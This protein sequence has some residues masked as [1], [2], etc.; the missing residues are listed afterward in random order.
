METTK[1]ADTIAMPIGRTRL[2]TPEFRAAVTAALD[3]AVRLTTDPDKA[4]L[5]TQR[6]RL[7]SAAKSLG[8]GF[9]AVQNDDGLYW[10]VVANGASV[11][12][13]SP[14]PVA[15]APARSGK[16]APATRR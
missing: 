5:A 10:Q 16:G 6:K 9:K 14:D 11:D 12:S 15:G 2:A 8:H 7:A 1:L 13:G 4:V 3:G